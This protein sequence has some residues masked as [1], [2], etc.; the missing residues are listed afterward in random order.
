MIRSG[1]LVLIAIC[2]AL[3]GGTYW[4]AWQPGGTA[5]AAVVRGTDEPGRRIPLDRER[6]LT[7]A[8]PRGASRIAV[9]P[10]GVRFL[11][12]PCR[13][14]YCVHSGWLERAGDFT[15]CLP[16]GVS[17]TLVGD[18]KQYDGIGY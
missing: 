13:G 15:A 12:S 2:A 9:R 11:S 4:F 14:K 8:G 6:R 10:G 18:E 1:D 17:L 3:V 7:V 5:V 16:N